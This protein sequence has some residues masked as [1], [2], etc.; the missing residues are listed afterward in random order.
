[1]VET[2]SEGA[3]STLESKSSTAR[4]VASEAIALP[5]TS[6]LRLNSTPLPAHRSVLEEGEIEQV[7]RLI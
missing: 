2:K 5:T 6:M 4:L 3:A 7:G 1:M